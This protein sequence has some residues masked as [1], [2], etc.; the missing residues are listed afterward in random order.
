LIELH[1]DGFGKLVDRTIAFDPGVNIVYGPNEAGKSTLTQ[2]IVATLYGHRRGKREQWKPWNGARYATRLRYVLRDGRE[3]EIQREFEHDGRSGRAID[4]NGNDVSAECST[5]KNFAPGEVHLGMPLEVFL[6]A[7]CVEQGAVAID[8]AR[9]ERIGEALRHALDGGPKEDAALGALERLDKALATHIGTKRATKNAPLRKLRAQL[10]EAEGEAAAMRARLERLGDVR[11]R[12]ALDRARIAGFREQLEQNEHRRR[13]HRAFVLRAR[14]EELRTIRDDLAALQ[15]EQALYDDV[16]TFPKERVAELEGAHA[17]WTERVR[18]AEEAVLEVARTRVTPGECSELEERARDGGALDDARFSELEG[19]SRRAA[20]ARTKAAVAADAAVTAR[21]DAERGSSVD[22]ALAGAGLLALVAA[23]VLAVLHLFVP[24]ALAAVAG[25]ALGGTFLRATI[26]RRD[27][28]R[29]AGEMQRTAD[30]AFADEQRAA[31]QVQ[32]ILAPLG[33]PSIEELRVRRHR[34]D[35]LRLRK[36]TSDRAQQRR[37]DA[38]RLRDEAAAAF[39]ILAR[40][41]G[42][43]GRSRDGALAAARTRAERKRTREGIES[44]LQMHSV[45]RANALGGEDEYALEHE[46]SE[47]LSVGTTPAAAQP[48]VTLRS[49]EGERAALERRLTEAKNDAVAAAAELNAAEM[50]IGSLAE[51]DE[52][53]AVLS[54]E[55]ARL[56]RFEAAVK[57][58]RT[59]IEERTKE[60]HHKFARRLEDYAVRTLAQVTNQRYREIRVD[61]TTLAVRLRAPETGGIVDLDLLSAG[62]REQ[63]FLVVRLAMARMFGEGLEPT[64]LLLDDPFAFWDDERIA[65]GFPILHAAAAETQTIVFTTSRELAGAAEANGAKRI[66]LSPQPELRLLRGRALEG[67]RDMPLLVEP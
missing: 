39:D 29:T 45:Q 50:H 62:T 2:A 53:I 21:R 22:G 44:R 40:T 5:A 14:L 56:E 26:A 11:T 57:L 64:P 52:R 61:P 35:E 54:A 59:T 20:D 25:L 66:D 43:A 33:V 34:Y 46:L 41:L 47:L 38:V 16:A 18:Q 55:C 27:L 48:G 6:N 19:A 67:E 23:V 4:R 49:I 60:S 12:L 30:G 17:T 36:D 15:A 1:V 58:A 3:F 7:S 32:A 28:R 42:V 51:I 13:S 10:E 37:A 63:A 65:R 8:G 24:A 31:A 9:A